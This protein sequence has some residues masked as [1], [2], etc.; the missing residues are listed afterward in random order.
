MKAI[1]EI[2][3][4]QVALSS[5]VAVVPLRLAAPMTT[6]EVLLPVEALG[7]EVVEDAKSFWSTNNIPN[8]IKRQHTNILS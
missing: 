8:K 2:V 5:V 7:E 6:E 3:P 4:R 1:T